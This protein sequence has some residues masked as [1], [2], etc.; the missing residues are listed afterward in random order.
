MTAQDLHLTQIVPLDIWWTERG[1][2]QGCVVDKRTQMASNG[3]VSLLLHMDIAGIDCS[4][5]LIF[6]VSYFEVTVADFRVWDQKWHQ[7]LA[8]SWL[9]WKTVFK[10]RHSGY[11]NTEEQINIDKDNITGCVIL[12]LTGTSPLAPLLLYYVESLSIKS[13]TKKK[14][15]DCISLDKTAHQ[16]GGFCEIIT[17][18]FYC[19]F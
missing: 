12:Q 15:S 18:N 17:E 8:M 10:H 2:L 16:Q 14:N 19:L 1:P 6:S 11:Q 3:F 7:S 4:R 13:Q 5:V 9:A